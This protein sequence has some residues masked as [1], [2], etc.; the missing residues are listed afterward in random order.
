MLLSSSDTRV[1][2]MQVC[3]HVYNQRPERTSFNTHAENTQQQ[4]IVLALLPCT[5][6]AIAK[7]E[8]FTEKRGFHALLCKGSKRTD[9]KI[10]LTVLLI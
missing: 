6:Q 2:L 4:L 7:I 10:L 9:K 8:R 3:V 5:L 1:T